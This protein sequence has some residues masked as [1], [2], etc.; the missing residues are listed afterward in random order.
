MSR[1]FE[2]MVLLSH[3]ER[4]ALQEAKRAADPRHRRRIGVILALR[5]HPNSRAVRVAEVADWNRCSRKF[6]YDTLA[7]YERGG[8]TPEALRPK[9]LGRPVDRMQDVIGELNAIQA[10]AD[11]DLTT[12]EYR[13]RLNT[14]LGLYLSP[15]SVRRYLRFAKITPVRRK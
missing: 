6:V 14:R 9:P 3:E 7:L 1:H 2:I 12:A 4:L 8:R 15:N 13:D 10:E 5:S 11:T